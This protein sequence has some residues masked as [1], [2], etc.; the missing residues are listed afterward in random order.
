MAGTIFIC[1]RRDDAA[2]HAG[3]LFDRLSA[4]Y[5]GRVFMDV[6]GI[7]PGQRWADV[8]QQTIGSCDVAV[9]LIGPR[10]L[11]P[12]T[13]GRPRLFSPD[14]VVRSE[15]ATALDRHIK[16]VPLLVGGAAVPV[17]S[18]LPADVVPVLDWQ[19]MRVDDD[20]FQHDT[21]RLIA[22]LSGHLGEAAPERQVEPSSRSAGAAAIMAPFPI[23]RPG[24]SMSVGAWMA[25]GVVVAAV[26]ALAI[27]VIPNRSP[28]RS[29]ASMPP[30]DDTART[31]YARPLPVERRPDAPRSA[32]VRPP[33]GSAA[34]A[35]GAPPAVA[36][37]T[38]AIGARPSAATT[39]SPAADGGAVSRAD[40]MRWA[41]MYG[42]ES[43]RKHGTREPLTGT[44]QLTRLSEGR[45]RFEMQYANPAGDITRYA[46]LF[47]GGGD[48]WTTTINRSNDREAIKTPVLQTVD[49]DGRRLTMTSATETVVWTRQ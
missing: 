8:I 25:V 4:H 44:L 17:A 36:A 14:D 40:S 33:S 29:P 49:F 30:A 10:W 23:R 6:D 24:T 35:G 41:G 31:P 11:V 32:A 48:R 18:Q 13:D 42:L 47:E 15:I 5:S 34:A 7:Q 45:F 19:V 38:E 2:G 9:V 26:A 21:D 46:G 3:R 43:L 37:A 27:A 1:Y 39:P 22:A 12:A 16:I 20:E 28:N